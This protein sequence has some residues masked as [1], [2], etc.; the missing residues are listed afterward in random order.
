MRL[1]NHTVLQTKAIK[2]EIVM[3]SVGGEVVEDFE[4]EE[5]D[6]EVVTVATTVVATTVVATMVVAIMVLVLLVAVDKIR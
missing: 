3:V 4:E 6:L 5:V 1:Q 2:V